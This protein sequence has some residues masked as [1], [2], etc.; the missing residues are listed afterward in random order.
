METVT[1]HGGVVRP[2]RTL[3]TNLGVAPATYYRAR[4]RAERPTCAVPRRAPP[5]ALAAVEPQRIRDVLHE[6]R[7]IDLAPA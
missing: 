1:S 5:R 4:R 7:F 2:L 6:D 3:C